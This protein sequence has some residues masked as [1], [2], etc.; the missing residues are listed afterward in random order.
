MKP[1]LSLFL[2]LV[3]AFTI[4]AQDFSGSMHNAFLITRMV[5]KF[6]IQPRPLNDELSDNLFNQ[7]IKAADPDRLI[8]S[9]NDINDLALVYRNALDEE[10]IY[11]KTTFLKK[12]ALV[13]QKGIRQN[14]SLLQF[15]CR[16]PFDFSLPEKYTIAE[17]TSYATTISSRQSKLYKYN[18]WQMLNAI[19][20]ME[21]QFTG[22]N[23]VSQKKIID[24][25]EILLRKR[26]YE[27]FQKTNL[28]ALDPGKMESLLGNLFCKA[29]AHCYDPHTAFMPAEEKE[30]FDE[31]LGQRP[32]R[33]GLELEQN[34]NGEVMIA[35]LQ[36]GSAAYKSGL[37]NPGDRIIALQEPG[38]SPV[39]VKASGYAALDSVFN[40]T[41]SDKILLTIKKPDGI[42]KQVTLY[43]ERFSTEEDEED[44]VQ[45]YILK[46][47]KSIG[48]ISI[49]DFYI[50][51]ENTETGI[52]GCANDVAKEIIKL[53]KENIEGLIIDI[54]YNGGGSVREAVDL[55]GIFIDGGPIALIKQKDQ[56]VITLK[57]VNAG[58]IFD[59]P[60]LVMVNGYSAS[61]SE[62]FAGALQDYNRAVVAG[63]PTY[64]KATGQLIFPLDTMAT[65]ETVKSLNT[66]NFIKITSSA[67]YRVSG[68]TAQQQGIVPDII[69]PDL[70]QTVGGK[71]KGEQF[72]FSLAPIDPNKYYKSYTPINKD[73]LNTVARTITD[74]NFYF[75][76]LK[77]YERKLKVIM[78]QNEVSLKIDDALGY[79][80]E[81]QAYFDAFENFKQQAVFTIANHG[82]H[83]ERLKS[84]DRLSE[85]DNETKV[86]LANDVYIGICYQVLLKMIPR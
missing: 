13:W 34:E 76:T 19:T 66:E 84:S 44:K 31:D 64:G 27:S 21:G 9:A 67:L 36:P 47:V 22:R 72:A 41:R 15:I 39:E 16:K 62:M 28:K 85:M 50:D 69:L 35:N 24:S 18:K 20:E 83:K 61:A 82:M 81:Q 12:I 55:S 3:S 73:E 59:G 40:E 25:I 23:P 58:R 52:Y 26:I 77:E 5:E 56:K 49:P 78:Q 32:L 79:K 51:W 17:D 33:F 63:T 74:T 37:L 57:D 11:Q 43:K 1:G 7:F 86:A 54:R 70:I 6:H 42:T 68:I 14:D 53:K 46:G 4:K 80:K 10:I 8:F 29:L 48:Y 38:K 60:L 75:K 45:G 71:E 65:A 30:A 2:F